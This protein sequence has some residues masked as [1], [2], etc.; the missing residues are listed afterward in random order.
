[1]TIASHVA[2]MKNAT[3]KDFLRLMSS[4]DF[5]RLSKP[6]DTKREAFDSAVNKFKE[7][8]PFAPHNKCKCLNK[9]YLA[10]IKK[11]D[12]EH[13]RRMNE[14]G[15]EFLEMTRRYIKIKRT[16]PAADI[17]LNSK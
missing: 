9:R 7:N 1:M 12:K 2:A 5:I 15:E 14:F 11:I 13:T 6:T 17:K 16:D 4:T 3:E 8:L 10:L